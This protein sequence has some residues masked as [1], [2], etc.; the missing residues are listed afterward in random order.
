[1]CRVCVYHGEVGAVGGKVVCCCHAWRF[2][3]VRSS[4]EVEVVVVV[5]VDGVASADLL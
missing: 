3:G 1:L 4:A 5:V 2:S